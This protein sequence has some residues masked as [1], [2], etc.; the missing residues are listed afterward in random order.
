M[1]DPE[2]FEKGARDVMD[3]E[4]LEQYRVELERMSDAELRKQY[5][6]CHFLCRPDPAKLP[7]A[8][9]IQKLVAI[10][11]VMHKRTKS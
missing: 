7:H 1:P 9:W 2:W 3:K 6:A 11:R 5:A 10:W 4:A 8:I